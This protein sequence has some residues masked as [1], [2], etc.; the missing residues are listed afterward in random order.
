MIR[1]L[2]PADAPAVLELASETFDFGAEELAT[3]SSLLA[4]PVQ[5]ADSA[6]GPAIWLVGETPAPNPETRSKLNSVVYCESA[7]MTRG[8][9]TLQMI[10]VHPGSQGQGYGTAILQA[11]EDQLRSF[12]AR[13]LV[14]ETSS[15]PAFD[16]TATFYRQRGFAEV[17]TIPDFYEPG[18]DKRVFTKRL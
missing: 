5:E 16:R 3:L 12:G 2:Q 1:R 17:A 8:T 10:A 13:L 6:A 18:D 14:V 9:W 4:V 11:L 7:A 15:I